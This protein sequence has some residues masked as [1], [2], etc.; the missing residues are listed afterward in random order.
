MIESQGSAPT[1]AE[2]QIYSY[3]YDRAGGLRSITDWFH[4]SRPVGQNACAEASSNEPGNLDKRTTNIDRDKAGRPIRVDET[5]GSGKDTEYRYRPRTANLIDRVSTDG[6]L[7][8]NAGDASRSYTEG[9]RTEYG[10]DELD[11]N[12]KVSVWNDSASTATAP[13]RETDLEWW[14]TGD[15]KATVKTKTTSNQRT[16]E[17]RFYDTAGQLSAR[18][19]DPASGG[20]RTVEYDYDDNGNR[21][22]DERG[23]N[24]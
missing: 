19:V 5:W 20:Q 23:G 4:H 12:T 2:E 14:P 1:V 18:V 22:V 6:Q 3:R 11:R 15:R 13:N 8:G 21:T 24:T 9:K 10:Y 7:G 17:S 16:R